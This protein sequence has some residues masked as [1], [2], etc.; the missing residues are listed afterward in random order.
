MLYTLHET[1]YYGAAPLRLTALMTRD[2]WS[3]P[4]N[5]ARNTDFGRRIFATADL[6]SNLTRRYRR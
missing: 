6:F 3:S 2:F 4:L 1:S 5:P